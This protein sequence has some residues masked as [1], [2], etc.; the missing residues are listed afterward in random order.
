[1]R[2]FIYL[3]VCCLITGQQDHRNDLSHPI[4]AD[5][6]LLDPEA[7]E[8]WKE[9][10]AYTHRDYRC[11]H[12]TPTLLQL[13][14]IM[15]EGYR[16]LLSLSRECWVCTDLSFALFYFQCTVISKWRFWRRGVH[17]H[18]N[19]CQNSHGERISPDVRFG[20]TNYFTAQEG[21]EHAY[22]ADN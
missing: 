9:P 8:C 3:C 6:C 20:C 19:G 1:M 7:N 10:P 18:R 14:Y 2:V 13:H 5:N 22:L 11:E 12:N 15:Q 16:S 4:H 21:S 17:I